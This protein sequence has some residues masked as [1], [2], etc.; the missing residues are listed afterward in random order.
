VQSGREEW[1]EDVVRV[2]TGYFIV[3]VNWAQL[4][5]LAEMVDATEFVSSI[6]IVLF[7]TEARAAGE[8]SHKRLSETLSKCMTLSRE[9]FV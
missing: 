2:L 5:R 1:G 9:R 7:L 6:G 8:R 4:S 3:H